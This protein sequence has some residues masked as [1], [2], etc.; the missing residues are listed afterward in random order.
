MHQA[1]QYS[2]AEAKLRVGLVA[3]LHERVPPLLYGG[4]ERV[5]S[6]LADEL[7]NQGHEVTLFAS[8]D[9]L[10]RARL[11]A[12]CE[13]AT[14]LDPRRPCTTALHVLMLERVFQSAGEFDVVH[15]HLDG[16][17]L[18]LARRCTVPTVT[19]LHGRLDLP[20]LD[21]L[22]REFMDHPFVSIS[23]AQRA[24]LAW[25][26]W[27]ATIHH[28]LPPEL[29]TPRFAPGS[30]FAFIGRISPEKRVDRAIEVA[31]R[32]GIPL[33]IAAK[34]DE[35]DR[36]YFETCIEPL[37]DSPLVEYVGEIG[38]CEKSAFLGG[39]IALLF[40]ID[41]PEPFGLAMI[42][43]L[44]CGTPVVA[45]RRG[46]VPEVIDHGVTGFVVE[47][48]EQA[49][50]CALAAREL[51]RRRCR[52]VFERRFTATRMA[53]DYAALYARLVAQRRWRRA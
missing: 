44:A 18:P 52:A 30:Y 32:T 26:S 21:L 19:T 43:A 24:P 35:T 2:V 53:A 22:H 3:P 28:G 13:R 1:L 51:D 39:A 40:L 34:I 17:P 25:A 27:A 23:D 41:W 11:V 8:G 10:T 20:G 31:C 12:G 38:E 49:V 29:H 50:A 6:Y 5:V 14:R 7:A 47:D 45:F 9:S 48:M 37:L 36:T 4:T 15:F 42:E 33:K 16:L 46:S